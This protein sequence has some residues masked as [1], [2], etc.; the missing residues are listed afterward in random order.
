LPK[1]RHATHVI[2]QVNIN[3]P[4]ISIISTVY[5]AEKMLDELVERI[6]S[7]IS[8]ITNNYEIILVNDGSI[9]KSW[10]VTREICRNNKKIIGVNLS[11]NFGQH[12]A[13]TAGLEISKGE[14]IVVMDCDLQDLP[15]EIPNLYNK[16]TQGFDL[17]FAQRIVRK[18]G[19]LKRITSEW[20]YRVFGYLTNTK[21]DPS[22]A[23]F[24]I[25]NRKVIDSIL[26]MKDY[27][28]YFPTMANWVGF[29]KTSIPVKHAKR[30]Q[31]K[32][33][34]SIS[35]LIQLAFDNIIA[36]SD[37]PLKMTV[38]FGFI[39]SLTSLVVAFIYLYR[40]I[41]GDI[42]IIGYTS[43]ILS[44][45]FLS[46]IIIFILGI[47]GIYIGKTFEKVKDR[48]VYII[49]KVLNSD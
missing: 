39:M 4:K 35:K 15:E 20:F 38:K 46:G 26:S 29:N 12:Y 33:N 25:Y 8:E 21:Q 7:S 45:W 1:N 48:P 28:R 14:W 41:M 27:I 42:E 32:S 17:V 9:D 11:R 37:K 43:L 31:G 19:F 10:E 3:N 22:I 6:A 36:F 5:Q 34:Y 30:E 49:D 47:V 16:A 24:G 40:Y 2:K 18:D 23:N 13:I 44:I